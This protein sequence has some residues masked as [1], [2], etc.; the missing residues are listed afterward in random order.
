MTT[1]LNRLSERAQRRFGL[2]LL[3]LL[4][5]LPPLLTSPGRVSA[6]T[7]SYLYLDPSRLLDRAPS[8]WDPNI[9]MGTVSHQTIGYLFPMGPY[10]WTLDRLGLPDWVAQ[11]LWLG[12]LI[13]A[14]A[15]GV[16]YVAKQLGRSGPGVVV[17]ALA[18][19]FSPYSLQYSA[20]LSVLLMP[21]AALGFL[22]GLVIRSLREGGWRAPALFAIT[23]QIVGGVNATSLVFAGVAPLL[24]ILWAWLGTR[25]V[26]WRRSLATVGRIGVV[27]IAT[28]LWWM[29]GLST[30]GGYGINILRYTETV[31]V[32]ARTSTP[33]EVLRGLGYWFFYGR[34]RV[35][36]WVEGSTNYTQSIFMILLTY[37]LVSLALLSLVTVRWR[38]RGYLAWLLLV[39]TIIAVGA[40]PYESP[41]P[42]GALFKAFATTSTAGLALRSTPRA[43]PL[44]SLATAMALGIGVDACVGWLRKHERPRL[45]VGVPVVVAGL[46]L[47]A[48]P[49]LRTGAFYGDNLLRDEDIPD[50]WRDV[51]EYVDGGPSDTRVLEIP[52]SDF[53]A[54]TWGDT[55]D[56]I[57]PGL[58]DRG[59]VARE[60][61]PYGNA[62]TADLLNA[63]DRRLQDGTADPNG[64]VEIFR[65]M[66]VGTVIVRNDIE[67]QRYNL[68]RPRELARTI[69][70]AGGLVNE[71]GF[72]PSISIGSEYP[73]LGS[74][75]NIDERSLLQPTAPLPRSVVVFDVENRSPIV[76]AYP[77]NS[78]IILSGDGE[79][80]VDA[81]EIGALLSS[82]AL[83]Y[84]A[85]FTSNEI[86]T[87]IENDAA[88]VIVISDTNRKRGR[89]WSSLR[90][91]LGETEVAGLDPLA[92][93]LT[94]A[95]LE[96]FP[97]GEPNSFSV[98]EYL[99]L[100][101]PRVASVRATGT[102]NPIAYTPEDRAVR[103]FDGDPF[104]S[105]RTS[106]FDRA[107]GDRI[108]LTLEE[109][110]KAD[111]IRLLQVLRGPVDR[112]ITKARLI[113]D[114][115][116]GGID[117]DL[118]PKSRDA[119]GQLVRFKG[120]AFQRLTIKILAT[121][122]ED[123]PLFSGQSAVGFAEI[124]LR[125]QAGTPVRAREVVR[126]PRDVTDAIGT[127]DNHRMLYMFSRLRLPP[128]PP[129]YDEE[130]S[131]DRRFD[132]S[133]DTALTLSGDARV[134][135]S[136]YDRSVLDEVLGIEYESGYTALTTNDVVPGC[137]TCGPS[138]A[139]DDD[140]GTSWQPPINRNRGSWIEAVAGKAQV[141][142][143]VDLSVVA[144]GRH[145]IPSR[146]LI[147]VDD[148][149]VELD[150]GKIAESKTE[151]ATSTV[152]LT[153]APIRGKRIRITVVD[154]LARQG[155]SF[156]DPTLRDMPIAIA[157]TGI[158]ATQ[159]DVSAPR[160]LGCRNDLVFLDGEPIAVRLVAVTDVIARGDAMTMGTCDGEPIQI[161]SGTHT[162]TTTRG[163]DT[164]IDIDRVVLDTAEGPDPVPTRSGPA[165]RVISQDKTRIRVAVDAWG[166][167]TLL[168]LGQSFNAGW[169][170]RIVGG[171]SLGTS[172]LVDGYANG[173]VV[174]SDNE[175]EIEVVLEWSPQRGV[176]TALVVSFVIVSIAA[177][178][179][180]AVRLRKGKPS[181][182][183][184]SSVAFAKFT[185]SPQRSI[186]ARKL[187]LVALALGFATAAII[188]PTVG[189]L[190]G[191]LSYIAMRHRSARVLLTSAAPV[192]VAAIGS[193][194]ALQQFRFGYD[195]IF[196]WPTLF[197]RVRTW[198]WLA[199]VFPAVVWYID[200]VLDADPEMV[201]SSE[202]RT[203][204][205]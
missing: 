190:M 47:A 60:L 82:S 21:W 200:R 108:E 126:V 105:W 8:M 198:G 88:A 1:L 168:V 106:A 52:G 36:P 151:G 33:N 110:I 25:E 167:D 150:V 177:L 102:G 169:N 63:L 136:A 58:I 174:K 22:L 131:L 44:V 62:P 144:D 87:L 68:V 92:E 41:T 147:E 80:A 188:N 132:V 186:P 134:S 189:V 6:D 67:W 195:P 143:H 73:T 45:A 111:R 205:T 86:G 148:E 4:A 179:A 46:V 170:A 192:L 81:S 85:S 34:D 38:H 11:R 139:F 12:S 98:V 65:R 55:V 141:F 156:Y 113:F 133:N 128:V 91:N 124:E 95:R 16:L 182:P 26:T 77:A 84:S 5:Y 180:I 173:W 83:V 115:Q 9:G 119:T 20:R 171:E 40:H 93:D 23:V 28:S 78:K 100:G 187:V 90:D 53:A 48:F 117:I 146:I 137:V 201:E 31:A 3:A 185:F 39:G 155:T 75:T 202:T 7:K 160:D 18:Y 37:G 197:P 178:L 59:F 138:A 184:R 27:S 172:I 204:D 10:Y 116:E 94:D 99:D 49:P 43:V 56:P 125:D 191:G 129:R 120:R 35:G 203:L 162:L 15:L 181:L 176:H 72:G 57:T 42:L 152:R 74:G 199:A 107:V 159:F 103:A 71:R 154:Y 17:A 29:A 76:R 121:N 145:S 69:E 149:S 161:T 50:Y 157:G 122:R 163:L 114:D 140:L 79:G 118:S 183:P 166:E 135:L 70:G 112:F 175:G 24:W 2:G 142:D 64:L 61:I 193:F 165:V 19:A 158:I 32:V 196:E 96:V 123:G 30:Q 104:T 14:A 194:V 13:M 51:A 101:G 164:A 66:G 54:Y 127:G 130:L 97:D 89:R 109:P 153:F